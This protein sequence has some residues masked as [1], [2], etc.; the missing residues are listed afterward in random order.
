L[1]AFLGT[2]AVFTVVAVVVLTMPLGSAARTV[3]SEVHP[4]PIPTQ[5]TS[6]RKVFLS[7]AGGEELDPRRSG[8]PTVD[9]DRIYN[10]LY[11]AIKA[12]GKFEPVLAP[13]DADVV[14]Q[15][16]FQPS[17]TALEFHI[18]GSGDPFL[19]LRILD[20]KS[21]VLLW[22]FSESVA[23]ANG[24]HWQEKRDNNF[25]QALT[26]LLDNFASLVKQDARSVK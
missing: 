18:G 9:P 7:N 22:A 12:G 5:I 21:N 13:A 19:T 2:A 3:P 24:S 16:H 14:L 25:N 10:Q 11:S 23:A 1:R 20:P 17:V 4:A 8:F 15:V 26:K 6:A